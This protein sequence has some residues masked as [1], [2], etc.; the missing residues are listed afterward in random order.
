MEINKTRPRTVCSRR[1]ALRYFIRFA[2]RT[3]FELS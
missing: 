1:F 3:F 2:T